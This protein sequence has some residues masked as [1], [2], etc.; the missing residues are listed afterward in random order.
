MAIRQVFQTTL[1]E[2]WTTAADGDAVGSIR[3]EYDSNGCLCCYKCVLYDD[4]AANLD[5]AAG[6]V[7]CYI[8][9]TGYAA[10]TATPDRT[11]GENLGAGVLMAA[12]T[13]DQTYCWVQIKGPATLNTALTAGADGNA[14]TG[15]GSGD[16]TLDVSGA[17]T[18][19]VCA[20]C[21]DATAKEIICDF[22]F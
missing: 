17:V 16:K 8:E 10:H 19:S 4:G 5:S 21:V 15:T 9:D 1:T 12:V 22:P 7:L 14:L 11:N 20:Y 3:W 13:V 18:D 2:T 6:D